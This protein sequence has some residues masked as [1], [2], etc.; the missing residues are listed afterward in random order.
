M[1]RQNHEHQEQVKFIRWA[2]TQ[3]LMPQLKLLFAIPNGGTRGGNTR[4][5]I[6]NGKMLK[7][8]GVKSGVPDLFLAF[9]SNGYHGLFIEMKIKPNKLTREQKSWLISL[10]LN[11]YK[12]VVCY[13][14]DEAK[15]EILKYLVY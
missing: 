13:S 9:P 10:E 12:S 11:G 6:I 4:Q 14:A 1:K 7:A 15:N 8:E 2:E 3:E 5:R